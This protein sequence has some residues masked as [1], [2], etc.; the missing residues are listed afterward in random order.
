MK[1]GLLAV[2]LATA[3]VAGAVHVAQRGVVE[4]VARREGP[5]PVPAAPERPLSGMVVYVSAGHGWLLHRVRHD[6]DPIAWGR[7][8]DH[9]NGMVED[10]WTADFVAF[11]LAPAL[12]Q[13][14][15][16]VIALRERDRNPVAVV[17]DDASDAAFVH[18][19]LGPVADRLAEDGEYTGAAPTG[20]AVWWLEVPETGHWYL[21]ARWGEAPEHDDRAVYTVRLAGDVRE[22]VVDQRVHG[23]HWWP[24]GDFCLQGGELVEVFLS[25]SGAGALSADAI[26]LGGGTFGIVP[27]FDHDVRLHPYWEVAMPHQLERLGGPPEIGQYACG[28]PVSDMR[29][30]PHWASWAAPADEDAVYLSIHTNASPWGAARG[31]T[32]FTGFDSNPKTPPDPTSA[33]LSVALERAVYEAVREHDPEY[34]TRGV[35]LGDFSEISP[36]HNELPATLLE[37]GFHDDRLDAK[38]LQTAQFRR[39]AARGIV[40]GLIRWR[41]SY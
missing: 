39:D 28:N 15:A 14:G 1:R 10:D 4:V 38:R 33:L 41:R 3:L 9:V 29:L 32:V 22:V 31:L 23:G 20:S 8:R 36:H 26:R 12:E 7:Q 11:D 35:Q 34:R 25:G 24:L 13:A 19:A 37:L 40:E 2:A 5:L 27:E 6:G 16:T 17:A 30:R 18:E 21:Y